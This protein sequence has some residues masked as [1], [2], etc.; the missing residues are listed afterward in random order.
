MGGPKILVKGSVKGIIYIDIVI[1][2]AMGMVLIGA[3][4][5]LAHS[6]SEHILKIKIGEEL[7]LLLQELSLSVVKYHELAK[8]NP[9]KPSNNT[10]ILLGVFNLVLP[11]KISGRSYE[12][13]LLPAGELWMNIWNLTENG[14]ALENLNASAN[15]K[16]IARTIGEPRMEVDI[17]LPNVGIYLQ[18][19][20]RSGDRPYLRYYRENINGTI[21]D[22]IT[23][24]GVD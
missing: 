4:S 3:S 23:L 24:G 13:K 10:K 7:S 5:L 14:I 12:I 21:F 1:F 16:L 22:W 17:T 18:G 2:V 8:Q 6:L 9:I 20:W 15:P 11:E 19:K